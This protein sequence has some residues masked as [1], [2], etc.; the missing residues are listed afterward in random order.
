[1]L[2]RLEAAELH[3]VNPH[4][5]DDYRIAWITVRFASRNYAEPHVAATYAVLGLHPDQVW[6]AIRE[7][8][9]TKLGRLYE[10]FFGE[11]LP[12]KKPAQ[13]ADEWRERA[14]L[15]RPKKQRGAGI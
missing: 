15:T 4:Y 1:V 14:A 12:P 3:E 13:A 8:R 10:E 7:E 6:N 2:A 11:S 9:K 5:R